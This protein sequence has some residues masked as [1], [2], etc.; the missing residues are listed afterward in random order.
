M[1]YIFTTLILFFEF[2]SLW[3]IDSFVDIKKFNTTDNKPFAEIHLLIPGQSLNFKVTDANAYQAE[4]EVLMIIESADTVAAFDKYV[5]KSELLKE[6]NT[7]IN[8]IDLKRFSLQKG[9]YSLEVKCSDLKADSTI[10][11][12]TNAN[13]SIGF[14][15]EQ[16]S[17]ADITLTEKV[18]QQEEAATNIYT[19]SGYE[20]IPNV[21]NFYSKKIN[22]LG[23]YTEIYNADK[24]IADDG[25]LISYAITKPN[26]FD[27]V[28]G[29]KKFKK[30]TASPLEPLLAVFN[31]EDLKSGNYDLLVEA[32][33]K[34]NELLA[35]K[36]TPFQRSKPVD[37]EKAIADLMKNGA[38]NTFVH[39]QY[40]S[41][42]TLSFYLGSLQPIAPP[43]AYIVIKNA[44]KSRDISIMQNVF[45][46]FLKQTYPKD[47]EGEFETYK[48]VVTAINDK[49]G[50]IMLHGHETDRGRMFLKYGQP[51]EIIPGNDPGSL[52]YEIWIYDNLKVTN[53]ANVKTIFYNPDLATNTFPML[54]SEIRGELFNYDWERYLYMNPEHKSIRLDD[55]ESSSRDTYGN[56][57]IR[58]FTDDK[59]LQK[60]LGTQDGQ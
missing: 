21:I 10:V 6:A 5:L 8:L 20:I 11:S 3:A 35:S 15:P 17:I 22:E 2:T 48:T 28:Q 50:T 19:K 37:A 32:R 44:I 1:R 23:F 49:F 58:I 45:Y 9:R 59:S 4:V 12:V 33:N 55:P 31:I 40:T 25:Y 60:D 16:I 36:R 47:T 39:Q 18:T 54:H 27:V 26:N 41:G 29:F 46:D 14:P 51:S 52:P 53:Q 43:D 57:A 24:V 42:D 56:K 38:V 34:K 30:A 13:F 7:Y